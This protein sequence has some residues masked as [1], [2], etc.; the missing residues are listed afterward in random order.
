MKL[1]VVFAGCPDGGGFLDCLFGFAED[2]PDC[3]PA[4]EKFK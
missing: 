4:A 2:A 1:L 3:E